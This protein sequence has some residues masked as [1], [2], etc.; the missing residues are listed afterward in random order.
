VIPLVQSGTTATQT[1]IPGSAPLAII[2]ASNVLS[3]QPAGTIATRVYT[4]LVA[5][6]PIAVTGGTNLDVFALRNTGTL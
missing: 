4:S 3:A 5:T 6:S 2:N 1:P